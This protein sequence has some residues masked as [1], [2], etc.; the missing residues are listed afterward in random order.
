ML[1]TP[2]AGLVEPAALAEELG[3]ENLVIVDTRDESAYAA[4]HLPGAIN[5]Q[6]IFYYLCLPQNGGLAGMRTHFARLFS[7]AGIRPTDRVVLYEDAQ[8]N[9]YGKSCR[10]W[11]LLQY[12]GHANAAVLHGG[13]RG[14]KTA[15]LP[16]T[17][18]P[19]QREPT[20]FDL[21]V[22]SG[23]IIGLDEMR[24]A[25]GNPAIALVDCRD[26]AE[27]LGA[28]S[29]PYGYDYCPRKGRI[30]GAVWLEWY[31][32][33]E[34]RSGSSWFRS[35]HEILE[36]FQQIGVTPERETIVY[37]FKGARASAVVMAMR[38]AG[39]QRVVNYFPSW[40]EWSRDFSLPV[41]EEYPSS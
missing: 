20:S 1:P 40:N 4:G 29:S 36:A 38:R 27:W 24:T 31:R 10:G 3:N 6:D 16:V 9:G 39:F 34:R 19:G 13:F 2:F 37:C 25:L 18:V 15:Q 14:W 35:P 5:I 8:D 26:Y 7:Q 30:P 22:T 28:N 21:K 11:L 32:I 41:D 23:H 12:L 33:M 17:E